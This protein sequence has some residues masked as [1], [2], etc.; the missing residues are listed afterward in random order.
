MLKTRVVTILT[1][2]GGVEGVVI[3]VN[4]EAYFGP[5]FLSGL[6]WGSRSR[7]LTLIVIA[8]YNIRDRS[9]GILVSSVR[10]R[11]LVASLT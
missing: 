1:R 5:L 7:L 9:S 8:N 10:R 2:V 3:R 4:G 6:G 11:G